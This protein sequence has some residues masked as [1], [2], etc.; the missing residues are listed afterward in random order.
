[1]CC[2]PFYNNNRDALY[3]CVL[4]LSL[5]WKFNDTERE[6]KGGTNIYRGG[7]L[8]SYLFNGEMQ[9]ASFYWEVADRSCYRS[10]NQHRKLRKCQLASRETAER[11]FC[12]PKP[13]VNSGHVCCY[14]YCEGRERGPPAAEASSLFTLPRGASARQRSGWH[15]PP[16]LLPRVPRQ[17]MA[18]TFPLIRLPATPLLFH[19]L[20]A[21]AGRGGAFGEDLCW[22]RWSMLLLMP[23][24]RLAC[25]DCSRFQCPYITPFYVMSSRRTGNAISVWG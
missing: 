10:E 5:D 23:L 25:C 17:S 13:R 24:P 20:R 3:L 16:A 1:M 15:S 9:V 14:I 22:C 8:C 2:V 4:V 7:N 19:C 21:P 11:R 12:L 18:R 6:I